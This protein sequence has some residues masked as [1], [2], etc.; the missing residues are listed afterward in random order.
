MLYIGIDLG[1]TNIAAGLVDK[2]G[3]IL[4]QDSTPT[5]ASR[6][7]EEIVKDICM[8]CKKLVDEAGYTMDDIAAIGMGCPGTVDNENGVIVLHPENKRMKDIVVD[9]CKIQG[10]AIKVIKDLEN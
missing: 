8:L 2:N 1:G 6:T 4:F 10:V 7:G 9:E 3:K 5:L